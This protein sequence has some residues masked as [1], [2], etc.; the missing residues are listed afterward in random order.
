M[1]MI[2]DERVPLIGFTHNSKK[3]SSF[4]I[5]IMPFL[6]C[7]EAALAKYIVE[8]DLLVLML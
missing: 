5:V 7:N 6:G 2:S 4:L 1:C 3:D 8:I